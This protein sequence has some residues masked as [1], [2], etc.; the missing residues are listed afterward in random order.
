M[1]RRPALSGH[2]GPGATASAQRSLRTTVTDSPRSAEETPAVPEAPA[3]APKP[4]APKPAAPK[5]ADPV[6]SAEPA[7]EYKADVQTVPFGRV[8]SL[9]RV[10]VMDGEEEREVGQYPDELPEDPFALYVRRYLDLEATI[11]LFEARLATLPA[12]DIESTLKTLN[13]QLVSP[14]V[15]GDL[16]AL[17]ERMVQLAERSEAR[18]GELREERK[19]QREQALAERTEIVERAEAVAAQPSEKTQWK[20][21][22]AELRDLLDRWK[23]Q[24]RGPVRLDKSVEDWLWKRF[25]AARTTFDRGRR[26]YFAALD[27]T[28]KDAKATKERLIKEAVALQTSEDWRG[29]SIAYRDLM[30]QWKRAG[31]ASRKEDDELWSRF[32]AAQQ[33]FFDARR[34]HDRATDEEFSGNLAKKEELAAEAEALLPVKD[35][36]ATKRKLRLIQDRWEEV[37]RVGSRDVDRIEGRLRAVERELREAENREWRRSNP[38]TK[39]RAEGML[40]QLESSILDLKAQLEAAEEAGDKK[41]AQEVSDALATKQMWFDQISGS[42]D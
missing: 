40:G 31:R 36:E 25:S 37:G 4:A 19:A 16:P 23:E 7:A 32:R 18:R 13:K 10:F 29:T 5:P 1:P 14:A 8:D 20:Q 11:N 17:R 22:G 28:Q 26:Q 3:P 34:A 38:E 35:I 41:R 39:A 42:V 30:D 24:Q 6:P 33:V 9:G 15:V 27:E 12:R 21:S 2:T